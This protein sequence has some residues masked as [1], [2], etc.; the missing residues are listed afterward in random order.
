M[1]ICLYCAEQIQIEARI[2]RYCG[3]DQYQPVDQPVQQLVGGGTHYQDRHRGP[4]LGRSPA[5]AALLSFFIS[6][7]GHFYAG[8]IKE[9]V[10]WFFLPSFVGVF[11]AMLSMGAGAPTDA[12]VPIALLFSGPFHL[13]Q[14]YL[15]YQY[16]AGRLT[17][18]LGFRRQER[19]GEVPREQP[20]MQQGPRQIQT[21]PGKQVQTA[22]KKQIRPAPRKIFDLD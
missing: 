6:G 17:P 11:L 1:K 21:V 13:Y 4:T 7:A 19:W 16:T 22:P 2:C 12:L 15:A 3:R 14:V 20:Y 8:A 5:I 18:V 9:G 10:L